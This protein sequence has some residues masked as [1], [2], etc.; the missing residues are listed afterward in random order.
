MRSIFARLLAP[1]SPADIFD[2]Y[3]LVAALA[4]RKAARP[5]RQQAARDG[6]RKARAQ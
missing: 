3:G 5:A 4:A 6:A 2:P 1:K